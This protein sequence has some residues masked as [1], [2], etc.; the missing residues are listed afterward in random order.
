MNL[1][2]RQA[3]RWAE[4]SCASPV[5]KRLSSPTICSP[6]LAQSTFPQIKMLFPQLL[7][8]TVAM[9][10][11]LES[12]PNRSLSSQKNNGLGLDT[13]TEYTG[14]LTANETEHFFY[15]AFESRNDPKNDPV[16]LWLQGGPGS[17][18][19]LGNLFENGPS[20]IGKDLKPIHNPHAW[21]NNATIVYL[22][23]PAD[24]GFSYTD[25]PHS[26]VNSA[27][28]AT[29]V[30]NFLEL[31]F[32]K[33]DHLPKKLHVTAESYGGHYG[34]ATAYEIL[35][36]PD[37]S[38]T[39]ESLVV[40]NG[41]TDPLNQYTEYGPMMCGKG[42]VAPVVDQSTCQQVDEA[43]KECIPLIQKCYDTGAPQDCADAVNNCN[44]N[45][46][47]LYP[48]SLN[49]YD[50][51]KQCE[52]AQD[53]GCYTETDYMTEW[54]NLP[55]TLEAIGAK[56]NWTGSSGTVYNDFTETSGDWMLPVVRDIPAILKEVPVLIYAGDKDWICNWLGQKK[57]T[58]ALEWPGKQGFNDAQFKPFSA[59]GKQA[60]EVRN[61]QQFTFLRIFDAGHMVPHDQP[62]ATSEM[63]NRWMS[64]D[65]QLE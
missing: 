59:G 64:G 19:E 54:L 21:N 65:H 45:V 63:I 9:G 62:V 13:V 56:H 38:F 25:K 28:A 51:T 43:A 27:Q 26:V 41:M 53:D 44:D 18:S 20:R 49:P 5:L 34:P 61:Y 57:W 48:S 11:S 3:P 16:I 52:Q 14:Y 30:Y 24:V 10:F 36:H 32:A 31:F 1:P 47:G 22:D 4:H 29:E 2:R 6:H 50:E 60:G 58:E 7:L 12:I 55:S 23:Q 37:R 42:G 8:A 33:Y 35:Q 17:S 15:W 46:L 40:G 39:L